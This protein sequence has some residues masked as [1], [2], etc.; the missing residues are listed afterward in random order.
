MREAAF[1]VKKYILF[2]FLNVKFIFA[3]VLRLKRNYF[4]IVHCLKTQAFMLL[5]LFKS[6][7]LQFWINVLSSHSNFH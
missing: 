2:I 6:N 3:I 5:E 4:G 1:E 7:V